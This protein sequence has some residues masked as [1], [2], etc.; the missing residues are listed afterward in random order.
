MHVGTH[1]RRPRNGAAA[2]AWLPFRGRLAAKRPSAWSL[3]SIG[4]RDP[5]CAKGHTRQ[6]VSQPAGSHRTSPD[7]LVRSGHFRVKGL[8]MRWAAL[9]VQHHHAFDGENGPSPPLRASSH[10]AKPKPNKSSAPTRKNSSARRSTELERSSRIV[11]GERQIMMN[12]GAARRRIH[13]WSQRLGWW[14]QLFSNTSLL[15]S[16]SSNAIRIFISL[17]RDLATLLKMAVTETLCFPITMCERTQKD[18]V[19]RFQSIINHQND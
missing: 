4:N 8:D 2:L 19:G 1:R 11:G 5:I 13:H 18:G 14:A 16:N 10:E 17:G 3:P 6:A 15:L 7:S 12:Q 9:Q